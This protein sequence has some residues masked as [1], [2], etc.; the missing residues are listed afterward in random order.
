MTVQDYLDSLPARQSERIAAHINN[1]YT[2]P[3]GTEADSLRFLLVQAPNNPDLI[4]A[5]ES[6]I[7]ID[8][9]EDL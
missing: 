5:A 2:C 1:Y 6:R 8:A 3:E 7:R 4:E 9:K